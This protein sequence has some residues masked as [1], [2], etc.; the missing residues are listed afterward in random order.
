MGV[1]GSEV[2]ESVRYSNM[3]CRRDLLGLF[4]AGSD[5]SGART[6]VSTVI[7]A[8]DHDYT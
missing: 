4:E 8:V 6:N 2:G 3:E 1:I 7:D 5:K